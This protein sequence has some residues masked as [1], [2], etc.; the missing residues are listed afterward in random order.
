MLLALL[1]VHVLTTTAFLLTGWMDM[2]LFMTLPR[3][4]AAVCVLHVCLS[5]IIVFFLHD[6][7][8]MR[9][10]GKEKQRVIVQ[11]ASGLVILALV[12]PHVKEFSAFLYEG[13]PLSV[14]QKL[15][16]FLTEILFFGAVFTHIECSFSRSLI[17]M[18]L[19]RSDKSEHAV[20]IAARTL[21]AI[22]FAVVFFALARFLISWPAA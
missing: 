16:V 8:D 10:Y 2:Q 18:G 22:L 19:I 21:C 1:I 5:L 11:R 13:L 15:L 3:I 6:G 7:A 9:R 17:S 14:P 4:L 12:H 20:D